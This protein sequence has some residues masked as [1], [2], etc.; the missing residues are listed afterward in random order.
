MTFCLT[1]FLTCEF[2]QKLYTLLEYYKPH[3]TYYLLSYDDTDEQAN[4]DLK[5]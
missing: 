1:W 5:S 2:I 3:L 4:V